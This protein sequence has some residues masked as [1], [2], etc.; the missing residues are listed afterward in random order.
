[1]THR[2]FR[3]EWDAIAGILAAVVA[4]VLHYEGTGESPLNLRLLRGIDAQFFPP[5]DRHGSVH[6]DHAC[7]HR[8]NVHQAFE[9]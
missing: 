4:L 9:K 7:A 5:C 6:D 3:L 2:L 1:M 8:P